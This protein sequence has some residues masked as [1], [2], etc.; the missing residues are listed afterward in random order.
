MKSDPIAIDIGNVADA[1][2][3]ALGCHA[4]IVVAIHDNDTIQVSTTKNINHAKVVQ[5]L[6]L[7]I[8][9]VLSDHDVR[10]LAGEAG[11]AARDLFESLQNGAQQ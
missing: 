2:T 7:A 1:V 11:E 6:A 10:V 4:S 3:D 9:A 5:N 8:H